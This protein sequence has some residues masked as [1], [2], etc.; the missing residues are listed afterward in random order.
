ML[1]P[2]LASDEE[3]QRSGEPERSGINDER[4]PRSKRKQKTTDRRTYELIRDNL[5]S[6]KKAIR[7][8]KV[9]L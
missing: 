6:V 1:W 7:T 8:R 4:T 5:G 2:E 3:D 9:L